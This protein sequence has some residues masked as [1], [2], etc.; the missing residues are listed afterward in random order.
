MSTLP[1]A[2]R[3]LARALVVLAAAAALAATSSAATG[4]AWGTDPSRPDARDSARGLSYAGLVRATHGPCVGGF[5]IHAAGRGFGCTHG[6]DPAPAGV[7]VTAESNDIIASSGTAIDSVAVPCIGDGTSG[8]RI[9][10]VYAV[11]SDRTDRYATV[12]PQIVTWAGQME[13]AVEKSAQQTGGTRYLRFVTTSGCQLSVAKV[14]LSATGDDSFGNT[15]SELRAAGFDRT[16]R[17]YVI[18]ADALVYCGIGQVSGTDTADAS[19]E[20]NSGPHYG[21]VDTGC[22]NRTDHNSA[23]HELFHTLGAVQPTAPHATGLFHCTDESDALCYSDAAG[24]TTT[25]TCP[26]ENEWLLDCGNDDYFAAN[27]A[28]GSYLASHWNTAESFYLS[29]SLTAPDP[30]V[31]PAPAPAPVTASDSFSGSLTSKRPVATFSLAVGSGSATSTLAF[32]ASGRAK[33]TPTLKLRILS[34][35]GTVLASG[36]G[37]SVLTVAATLPA[38]TYRWEVSGSTSV[39]FTLTV[40]HAAC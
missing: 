31:T 29:P 24:V 30:V 33:T 19:N 17:K 11:A 2:R 36:S 14:V 7:D 15:I 3:P 21:R 22:W 32:S 18:W 38:G 27:P 5:E 20:A 23:L 34:S 26:V 9:Q 8:T 1:A 4:A 28:P 10:A 13:N 16:D 35:S 12:A 37:T 6:P 39:S 40:K 25:Q